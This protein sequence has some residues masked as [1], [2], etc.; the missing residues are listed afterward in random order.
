MLPCEGFFIYSDHRN[1]PG[2]NIMDKKTYEKPQILDTEKLQGRATT[3]ARS[4]DAACGAGPI[5][6]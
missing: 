5:D 2:E 4:D 3:C 1:H 6:S